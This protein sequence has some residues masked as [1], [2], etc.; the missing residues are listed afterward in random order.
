LDTMVQDSQTN[1]LQDAT[2]MI[3]DQEL[4]LSMTPHASGLEE[5]HL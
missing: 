4:V 2:L 1:S 3:A 5:I